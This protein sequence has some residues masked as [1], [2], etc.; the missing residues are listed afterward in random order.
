MKAALLHG[1]RDLR[2]G[3]VPV[4]E[5]SSDEV[6]L[7]VRAVGVCGSD[8]HHYLEGAIG[9]SRATEPF[10]LG[11][12][13]AAE[14]VEGGPLTPGTLVAVDPNRSCGRCEWCSAGHHNLC[15]H[16]QFAGVPPYQ[17]A[18]SEYI[19][20]RP[21]ELVTLPPEFDA[22]TAALL[23]PLGVAIHALD[24][25]RLKPMASV[26][27]IGAGPIGLLMLQVA[28]WCGAG[29]IMV[30]DPLAYRL[31]LA[32]SFGADVTASSREAIHHS[33]DGRGVDVVLEAT[34]SPDGPQHAAEVARIGG[35]LVL[36]GIPEGDQFT[37]NASLVRRKGLTIKMSRRMG[38]VYPRAI[39][40]V[41]RGKVALAP[42][43]T[44]RFDLEQASEAF[45]VHADY[46]DGVIKSV[47]Y[48]WGVE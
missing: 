43:V 6:L 32:A 40:M 30:I 8:L 12:E 23:E 39:Q 31:E 16:V 4:P 42:L 5:R 9:S 46:R 33:T 1:V 27:I 45:E 48:P 10:I 3:E 20:A 11:H 26:A 15:P 29:Q 36:V 18:L 44:H 47:I 21:E 17:G 13:F 34:T 19:T 37:L 35:R 28:R 38:N 24:L 25:A 14:V 22:A 2:L 7:K 41:Q